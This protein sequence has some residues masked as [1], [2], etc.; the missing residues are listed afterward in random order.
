MIAIS[1][2]LRKVL[3]SVNGNRSPGRDNSREVAPCDRSHLSVNILA[4]IVEFVDSDGVLGNTAR[5]GGGLGVVLVQS[6]E[7]VDGQQD[8]QAVDEYPDDVEDIM[9]VGALNRCTCDL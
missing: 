5:K 3:F 9:S 4:G 7:V 8:A 6:V 2:I 1:N